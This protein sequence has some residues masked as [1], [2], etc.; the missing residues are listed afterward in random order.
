MLIGMDGDYAFYGNRE[1]PRLILRCCI[2]TRHWGNRRSRTK[3]TARKKKIEKK[4]KKVMI[5]LTMLGLGDPSSQYSKKIKIKSINHFVENHRYGPAT[6]R[7][8][9]KKKH[10]RGR[11]CNKCHFTTP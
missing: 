10:I 4:K 7:K 2:Q 11:E 8:I 9:K 3:I 6:A 1:I 5:Q